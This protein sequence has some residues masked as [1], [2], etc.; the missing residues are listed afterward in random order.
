MFNSPVCSGTF[1][2]FCPT[3]AAIPFSDGASTWLVTSFSDLRQWESFFAYPG[4]GLLK[5]LED[6]NTQGDAAGTARLIQSI[7]AALLNVSAC[8]LFSILNLSIRNR[9]KV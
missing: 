1:R 9:Y 4:P 2:P 7:S 8:F 6:R 3:S 5:T